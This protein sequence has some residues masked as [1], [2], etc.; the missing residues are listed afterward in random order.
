MEKNDRREKRDKV[1]SGIDLQY[2][3]FHQKR[4]NINVCFQSSWGLHSF[5]MDSTKYLGLLKQ[6]DESFSKITKH[7]FIFH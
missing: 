7:P 3:F 4:T 2:F 5:F 6:E 1:K